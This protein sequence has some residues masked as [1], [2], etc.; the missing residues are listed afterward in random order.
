[1]PLA[2]VPLAVFLHFLGDDGDRRARSLDIHDIRAL[3][4]DELTLL[5]L[6]ALDKF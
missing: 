3:V 2:L 4:R 1:M 6:Q 5:L